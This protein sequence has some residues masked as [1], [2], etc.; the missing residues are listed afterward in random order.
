V[1]GGGQL[2]ILDLSQMGGGGGNKIQHLATNTGKQ[3]CKWRTSHYLNINCENLNKGS[4]A[5]ILAISAKS[6]TQVTG[7]Q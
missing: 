3:Y 4:G 7:T 5:K 1:C 2:N 6:K